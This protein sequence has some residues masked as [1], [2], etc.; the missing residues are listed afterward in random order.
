MVEG[1][2]NGIVAETVKRVGT[3]A[4]RER[5]KEN[6]RSQYIFLWCALYG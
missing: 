5:E 4:E 2:K 1:F 3:A 6:K